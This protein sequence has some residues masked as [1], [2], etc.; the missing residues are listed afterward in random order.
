MSKQKQDSIFYSPA[1]NSSLSVRFAL[2][3]CVMVT[4]TQ[5]VKA[6]FLSHLPFFQKPNQEAEEMPQAV[7][8]PKRQRCVEKPLP[9]G[10]SVTILCFLRT[11]KSSY[12]NENRRTAQRFSRTTVESVVVYSPA[13]VP[14]W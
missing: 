9:F 4:A 13:S 5:S 11:R 1:Q 10:I 12:D 3:S 7:I 2:D 14:S 6:E 8:G